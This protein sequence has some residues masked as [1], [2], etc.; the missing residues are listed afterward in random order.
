MKFT[1]FSI[2]AFLVLFSSCIPLKEIN[3]IQKNPSTII[4]ND[5]VIVTN[6]T[7]YH[8][9]V[10][11]IISLNIIS[12]DPDVVRL[13]GAQ[14]T[15]TIS[16]AGEALFYISGLSVNSLG[17]IEVPVIGKVYVLNKTADQVKALIE[18][19]L[20]KVYNK[21]SVTVKVQLSGIYYTILG[22]VFSP[23]SR[24]VYRNRLNILEA[25]AISGD[26]PV[27]AKR[28]NIKLYREFPEGK[29]M[30]QLD[31]T[32]DN[33]INSE[34]FYVQPNDIFVVDA[35]W[36]KT[37]GIGVNTIGTIATTFSIFSGAVATYFTIKSFSK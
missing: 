2:S 26:L 31:L 21:N 13:F 17:E 14:V 18:E 3:Y 7:D 24:V 29:K 23:G 30:I 8:F 32:Q 25:I 34:Y 10:D 28:K 27:T 11:D 6:K 37:W 4:N 16:S 15:S 22:E 12:K 20:Y 35:K 33:I 36:Q 19:E 5:G 1:F 9:H